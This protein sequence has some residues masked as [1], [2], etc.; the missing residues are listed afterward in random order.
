MTS[1]WIGRFPY[2]VFTRRFRFACCPFAAFDDR[3]HSFFR[4]LILF[5]LLTAWSHCWKVCPVLLDPRWIPPSFF[6]TFIV[7]KGRH[8]CKCR[9]K[10]DWHYAESQIVPFFSQ[11]QPVSGIFR[12]VMHIMM[13]SCT[14]IPGQR[15][16]WSHICGYL[17]SAS[18][19]PA[20]SEVWLL[21]HCAAIGIFHCPGASAGVQIHPGQNRGLSSYSFC[22]HRTERP[23]WR[24]DPS[25]NCHGWLPFFV[26][27]SLITHKL[28]LLSAKVVKHSNRLPLLKKR[29][30]I[31][32][33][34]DLKIDKVVV[35]CLLTVLSQ[36]FN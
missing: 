8:G 7:R 5:C 16:P 12:K 21:K 20:L 15:A 4:F 34:Q 10:S 3:C 11:N 33:H 17:P 23:L 25:G 28:L 35:Y 32:P 26:C 6:V 13:M 27:S 30:V 9:P 24:T 2:L 1:L 22:V 18:G 19:I 31:R 36:I 29:R 14:T